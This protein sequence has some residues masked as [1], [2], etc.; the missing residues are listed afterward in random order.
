M[1]SLDLIKIK[2]MFYHDAIS[3]YAWSMAQS[4]HT[5]QMMFEGDLSYT[6][7]ID[8]ICY[9][10]QP[11]NESTV[12][13]VGYVYEVDLE[14]PKDI[15]V[16]TQ[17]YPF[18]LEKVKPDRNNSLLYRKNCIGISINQQQSLNCR[19]LIKKLI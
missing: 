3:L 16:L 9:P 10:E 7:T 11:Q 2:Y 12:P 13:S 5:G 6:R 8:D 19:R 1:W 17:Y 4:L 15:H 18:S 14:Y